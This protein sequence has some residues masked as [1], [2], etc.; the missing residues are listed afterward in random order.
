MVGR[1]LIHFWQDMAVPTVNDQQCRS[2]NRLRG[3][4]YDSAPF[5]PVLPSLAEVGE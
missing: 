1:R 2:L 3:V 5:S 4:E